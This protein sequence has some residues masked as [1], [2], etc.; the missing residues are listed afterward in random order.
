MFAPLA[1]VLLLLA[2]WSAY[3]LIAETTAR[4]M[5][6]TRRA[7][8]AA[9]GI[10]LTCASESW[11]GYPFRFEYV[12]DRPV[13]TSDSPSGPVAIKPA[14]IYVIA[15]AYNPW[16]LVALIDGPS[17]ID[18]PRTGPLYFTHDRGTASLMI[19]DPDQP[20]LSAEFRRLEVEGRVAADTFLLHARLRSPDLIDIVAN[21][22]GLD[23]VIPDK[24]ALHLDR[25][26]IELTAPLRLLAAPGQGRTAD[27]TNLILHAGT[28]E[29]TG[30][31]Q[32]G[33]DDQSRPEG[34]IATETND[35]D[36]LL[37]TI[38]TYFPMTDQQRQT[39]K[40]LLGLLGN[41]AGEKRA[42][43]DFTAKNGEL[44]WGPLKI[45]D[46]APYF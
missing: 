20:R 40:M 42:K 11:G 6:E 31:G 33:L 14:R 19:G 41:R 18:S 4:R 38:G 39:I 44:Y 23:L 16:H 2:G 26:A 32:V 34:R 37:Q 5:A 29:L 17:H 22:T 46:L 15:Q 35:I 25:A 43:A 24:P 7:E 10:R 9:T 13:L 45:A 21:A 30:K 12:C 36:A 3:W 28:T 8:L 1:A 27:I